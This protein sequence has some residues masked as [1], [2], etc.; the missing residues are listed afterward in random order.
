MGRA[1][2]RRILIVAGEASGEAI[3]ARVRSV[4]PDGAIRIALMRDEIAREQTP[5]RA[6]L[7]FFSFFAALTAFIA[8][9]GL[10][11]LVASVVA[12]QTHDLAVRLAL[13]GR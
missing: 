2:E 12:E 9:V 7:L 1:I 5:W 3:H 13:G 8:I 4:D 11:G 10:Y 6:N